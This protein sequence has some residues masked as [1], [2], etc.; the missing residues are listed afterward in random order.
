MRKSPS[1]RGL[2]FVFRQ[3]ILGLAEIAWRWTSA[4]I[5]WL[6]FCFLG[7]EYLDS[8]P[9]TKGDRLLLGS[10]VPSLALGALERILLSGSTRFLLAFAIC[11]IAV[12]ITWVFA[13]SAGRAATLRVLLEQA[14]HDYTLEKS[15][16]L[17]DDAQGSLAAPSRLIS[18]TVVLLHVCRAAL[19]LGTLSALFGAVIVAG[20]A[21]SD[22]DPHPGTAVLLFL[23]L[24]GAIAI[25]WYGLDWLLSTAPIFAIRD[26]ESTLGAISGAATFV[27]QNFGALVRSSGVFGA[28]HLVIFFA[29]T[30]LVSAPL[31]MARIFPPAT[32]LLSIFVLTL[33]Y[34]VL[35]D[36]LRVARLAA[37]ICMADPRFGRI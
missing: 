1:M 14:A 7:F 36:F 19:L 21:A 10:G 25:L 24:S 27:G 17:A 8:L 3:P 26:G 12:C 13:A 16:V 22:H 28:I 31:A 6:L 15:A 35:I 20:L 34:F 2:R 37:Y 32:I 23:F 11:L 29:A 18:S 4:T 30:S 5:A 33:L 9:V